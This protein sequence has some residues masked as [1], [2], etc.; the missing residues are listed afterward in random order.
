MRA[1][2]SILGSTFAPTG[3]DEPGSP[4]WFELA[5]PTGWGFDTRRADAIK[6]ESIL[7]NSGDLDLTTT[8]GPTGYW[9]AATDAGLRRYQKRNGL[10]VDGW[11]QPDG[12]TIAHM[13]DTLGARLGS[14][15]APTPEDID[16]HHASLE[17]GE[18]PLVA[19]T[20][21]AALAPIP[22]LPDIGEAGRNSNAG[23]IDWLLRNQTGLGGVPAQFARYVTGLGDEGLA[24]TRD[25][26]AQFAGRRPDDADA[27]VAG[28]LRELP[29]DESRRHFLGRDPEGIVPAGTR[30][31]RVDIRT[32]ETREEDDTPQPKLRNL[33]ERKDAQPE[34]ML[35]SESG[36][37][38]SA[39]NPQTAQTPAPTTPDWYNEIPAYRAE[40]FEGKD[41]K[42]AWNTVRDA[43]AG[44][45]GM[46]EG[47]RAAYMS[48]FAAE[49]GMRVDKDG[50]AVAGI[51]PG[52]I[53]GERNAGR[54]PAELDHVKT[55]ADLK[56]ADVPRA[57]QHYFDANL[58]K[59]GGAKALDTIPDPRVAAAIA[60]TLYRSGP[61]PGTRIVQDAI[62]TAG[63][64]VKVDGMFRTRTL[65][66]VN[67]LGGEPDKAAGFLKKLDELRSKEHEKDKVRNGYFR[68]R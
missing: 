51:T 58:A 5:G 11:L 36:G 52:F 32:K 9:G 68:L 3:L 38:E 37:G 65:D 66:A 31:Q 21:K 50:G 14:Y 12:P 39:D 15:E 24:Q 63:S 35:A 42:D 56:P 46:G 45:A 53:E 22:H 49:G 33:L 62:G 10:K 18:G 23:Q 59:V 48:I 7:A 67:E 20:P 19:I 17:A 8:D 34:M 29:D 47:Q 57:M 60:D 6:V 43:V 4:D 54:W 2:S 26:V 40:V 61:G 1:A 25:F 28:I 64:P 41:Q 55:P 30:L 44:N 27:L 16:A 13:R